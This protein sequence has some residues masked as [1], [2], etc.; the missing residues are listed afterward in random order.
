[1]KP[2]KEED[3]EKCPNCASWWSKGFEMPIL[4]ASPCLSCIVL[5]DDTIS[6]LR[7]QNRASAGEK[8]KVIAKLS[9]E[10]TWYQKLFNSYRL[11]YKKV[12]K[13]EQWDLWLVSDGFD[14]EWQWHVPSGADRAIIGNLI[15]EN[16]KLREFTEKLLNHHERHNDHQCD[17]RADYDAIDPAVPPTDD[18]SDL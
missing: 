3:V 16:G 2:I 10:L 13:S 4:L 8:A 7:A 5:M 15:S 11:F 6:R 12:K 9:K 18:L 17:W 14:H 1:M